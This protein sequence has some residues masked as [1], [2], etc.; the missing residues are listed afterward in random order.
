MISIGKRTWWEQRDE[1]GSGNPLQDETRRNNWE[2]GKNG[3]GLSKATGFQSTIS[4]QDVFLC[5]RHPGR[6][7]VC[8]I[9][10]SSGVLFLMKLYAIE[11]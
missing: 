3:R 11:F 4:A 8:R 1:G 7:L 5:A 9:M 10:E 6:A 2:L